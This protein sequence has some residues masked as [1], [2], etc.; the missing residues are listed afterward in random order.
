MPA[1]PI[2][3]LAAAP[4]AQQRPTRIE[5]HGDVRIDDYFWLRERENPEV[6]AYLEA[7]NSYTNTAM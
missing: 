3:P 6:V 4:S 1:T 7:E 5:C 2:A